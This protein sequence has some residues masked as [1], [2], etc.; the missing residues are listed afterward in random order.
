MYANAKSQGRKV[1]PV[2][3]A[4]ALKRLELG[5]IYDKIKNAND[6]PEPGFLDSWFG[7]AP[8]KPEVLSGLNSE[9]DAGIDQLIEILRRKNRGN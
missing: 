5:R 7:S 3:Q 6:M 8:T 2:E 1:G 9:Y 4:A